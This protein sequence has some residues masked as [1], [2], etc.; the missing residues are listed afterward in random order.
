MSEAIT[1]PEMVEAR[2]R[3]CSDQIA[4]GV[5]ICDER[6]QAFLEAD[7]EFDIAV[8]H[9]M[10]DLDGPAYLK[11][12]KAELATIAERKARDTADAAYRYADRRAKALLAELSS[13]QSVN[14]SVMGMYGAVGTVER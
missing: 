8:A 10:V 3:W 6:Y 12:F 1:T 7:H 5:K 2:M 14:K 9:A 11:K 4:K 13:L